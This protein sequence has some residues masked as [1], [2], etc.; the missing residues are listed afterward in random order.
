M[1][2]FFFFLITLQNIHKNTLVKKKKKKNRPLWLLLFNPIISYLLLGKQMTVI[3][4][5]T[6]IFK[7]KIES[8]AY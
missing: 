3:C 8:L 6:I 5:P 2:S 4:F 7:S 1:N